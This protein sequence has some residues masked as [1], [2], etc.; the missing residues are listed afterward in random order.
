MFS[1]FILTCKVCHCKMEL[2][3]RDSL[4]KAPIV[5]QNCGQ[6]LSDNDFVY[7]TNAMSAIS[8]LPSETVVDGS[9]VPSNKGFKIDLEIIH[10]YVSSD[11]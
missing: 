5:C 1:K 8:A 6:Q 3:P 10:P 4:P 7:L 2:Q 11:D 9:W